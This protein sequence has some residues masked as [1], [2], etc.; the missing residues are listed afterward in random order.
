MMRMIV[1]EIISGNPIKEGVRNTD[2]DRISGLFFPNPDD[3][4][5]YSST[6]V[7]SIYMTEY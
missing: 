1:R 7:I 4:Y 2:T 6:L 5:I 3:I